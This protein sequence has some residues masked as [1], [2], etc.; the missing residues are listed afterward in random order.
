MENTEEIKNDETIKAEAAPQ[1]KAQEEYDKAWDEPAKDLGQDTAKEADKEEIETT[2]DTKKTEEEKREARSQHHGS[3]ESLEKALTDTKSYATKLA[4]EMAELKRKL[5]EQ[6]AGTATKKDVDEQKKA[7]EKA[8]DDLDSVKEKIYDDYPE[9]KALLDPIL[10]ETRIL[11]KELGDIK[12]E[13]KSRSQVDAQAKA[14]EIFEKEVKPKVV[15]VHKDF[16]ELMKTKDYWEWAGK[17]RPALKYA[18]MDSGDPDDIIYAIT[19]YKKAVA[20]P[21]FQKLKE[22]EESMKKDKMIN[23]Q[24]LR[25]G[26]SSFPM[27]QKSDSNDYDSGWS[28]ADKLL[29][30]EGIRT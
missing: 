23:A 26:S 10:N 24:T 17:Q 13:S 1:D 8:Q 20:A 30:K 16:D 11:K 21:E 27:R 6:E 22:K 5:A 3:I 18:A 19:E 4:E 14:I 9:L 12:A 2:V 28:D 25:G 7:A 15:E 29:E